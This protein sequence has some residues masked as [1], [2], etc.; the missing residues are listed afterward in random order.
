[1]KKAKPAMHKSRYGLA[2]LLR[3]IMLESL[4]KENI[5]ASTA[6]FFFGCN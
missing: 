2:F 5:I 1:M 4:A 6:N 3:A